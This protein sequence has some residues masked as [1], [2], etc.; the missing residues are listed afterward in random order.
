MLVPEGKVYNTDFNYGYTEIGELE[1]DDNEEIDSILWRVD[2]KISYI[3]RDNNS[4]KKELS[5]DY[6]A[7]G[8]RIAKHIYSSAGVYETS[9]FYMRDAS[10]NVMGTY[11]LTLN[12]EQETESFQLIER[13]IYG[14]SRL[15][16]DVTKVEMIGV[17]ELSEDQTQRMLGDKQYEISNHLGNVLSVVSDVKLPVVDGGLI[18]SYRAVV[19]SSTDYSP[20]GVG[21]VGRS[22]SLEE[23]RYGFQ[24]QEHDGEL[25]E[26]AVNYKYR[27][28]DPR[29]GRFFSVDPLFRKFAFYSPFQFAS[30]ST[31]MSV[32]LEGLESSTTGTNCVEGLPSEAQQKTDREFQP[33]SDGAGN[34]DEATYV[35]SF[36][37]TKEQYEKLLEAYTT[38]P[39][40]V[41]NN[42]NAIYYPIED[43]NDQDCTLGV[44]DQMFIQLGGVN[45]ARDSYVQLTKVTLGANE[46]QICATTLNWHVD[47]GN[48]QFAAKYD[49]QSGILTFSVCNQTRV[50]NGAA[51]A[52]T[53]GFDRAWQREQWG[54]VLNNVGLFI[55]ATPISSE[56]VIMT[57]CW[58]GVMSHREVISLR[59]GELIM[60]H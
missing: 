30:N 47:A 58:G 31:I 14:S 28:E 13:P 26:G 21:L 2:S 49:E 50:A 44:G 36:S 11:E 40:L 52:T 24:A 23:Y 32:E 29:L 55:Q 9:T 1:R 37:A 53:F 45:W 59:D 12:E 5:F 34:Y 38:N 20:F 48:V 27:V 7:M 25:W 18:V 16:M 6:D 56:A 43:P 17:A 4:I 19:V 42:P 33:L 57:W 22:Y 54:V 41:Q 39:G 35:V 10:G 15:G 46:F 60:C 8:N 3:Y 51:S